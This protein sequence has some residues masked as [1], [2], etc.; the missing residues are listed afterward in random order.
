[1]LV[2]SN[3][4]VY[5]INRSS[6]KHRKAQNFLQSNMRRLEV[7]HQNIFETLRLLT[8]PKFPK[9]MNI[10]DALI[11]LERILRGLTVVSPDYRTHRIALELIR[12][13]HLASDQVFDAY[14]AATALTNSIDAIATDNTKDL[15]KFTELSVHNPFI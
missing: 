5:S 7:A 15:R 10:N 1:M 2:D 8:H 12:K 4:L 13:H 14:L 6:P 9:P 11:A 3:I